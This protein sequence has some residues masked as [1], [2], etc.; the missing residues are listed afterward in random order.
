MLNE[1]VR[2]RIYDRRDRKLREGEEGS[3]AAGS[4]DLPVRTIVN[5]ISVDN[6]VSLY[7]WQVNVRIYA[8]VRALFYKIDI[9]T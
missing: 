5:V 2:I 8:T 1:R 7:G 4:L 3:N 9:S 6:L